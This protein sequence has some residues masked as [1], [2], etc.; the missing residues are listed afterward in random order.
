VSTDTVKLVAGAKNK[1]MSGVAI[2]QLIGSSDY[3]GITDD[4]WSTLGITQT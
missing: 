1:D 2:G 4:E 3:S